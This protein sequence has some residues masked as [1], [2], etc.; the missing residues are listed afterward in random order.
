M[1]TCFEDVA[2]R[3]EKVRITS[4]RKR[5]VIIGGMA[6][7]LNAASALSPRSDAEV[8]VIE[9][10]GF[11]GYG[12]CSLP[13]YIADRID[14]KMILRGRTSRSFRERYG[15]TVLLSH[16]ATEI[17]TSLGRIEVENLETG[18][19]RYLFYDS[20]VL[21]TG[22]RIN[23]LGLELAELPG[24]FGLRSF[25]DAQRLKEW[26]RINTP[27]RVLIIGAS[28]QGI[29]LAESF[30]SRGMKVIL[31]DESTAVPYKMGKDL[32]EKITRILQQKGIEIA[33]GFR[34][35]S[36]E[37]PV[38]TRNINVEAEDGRTVTCDL[39]FLALGCSPNTEL[40]ENAGLEIG[41]AGGIRV[42]EKMKTSIHRVYAAGDCVEIKNTVTGKSF[43][44]SHA[45]PAV[46][47]GRTAGKNIA[48]EWAVF[49][50]SP[51]TFMGKIF[52]YEY[53]GTGLTLQKAREAG[54]KS[55]QITISSKLR[56]Y[57]GNEG[58]IHVNLVFDKTD[59][60]LLGVRILGEPG[61]ASRIHGPVA[62]LHARL[63]LEDMVQ[64]DFG[65]NP[66]L[67]LPA[68]PFN[69]AAT[70]ALQSD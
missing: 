10:S 35:A 63:K 26:M 1:H 58:E 16:L 69:V 36:F 29:A 51:G 20:L 33:H 65:Y 4:G 59:H 18:S 14:G 46:K 44:H 47:Q 25:D 2:N 68:D 39:V 67:S 11:F 13:D 62:A 45:A 53:A 57:P 49:K 24:I 21:A 37:R 34:P 66:K 50:G 17:D 40:A 9:G 38:N 5:V 54:F 23:T 48:G 12:I 15:V 56:S 55:D 43:L 19:R 8:T 61:T 42:D 32:S 30:H 6:A 31:A 28:F 52:D 22:G 27:R 7:G 70:A 3:E 41:S 64:I 60:R